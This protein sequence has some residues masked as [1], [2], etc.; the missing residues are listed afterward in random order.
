M[1]LFDIFAHLFL[2][3]CLFIEARVYHD[4]FTGGHDSLNGKMLRDSGYSNYQ[5]NIGEWNTDWARLSGRAH[6]QDC[7][8][9]PRNMTLC[10]D[11]G[12]NR[13]RLPNL[14]DHDTV[15][16]ATQQASSWNNL[17]KIK[18]HADA[19]LFLCSLFSP[20]CLDYIIRPCKSLCLAVKNGCESYLLKYGY[21]WPDMLNCDQ[22]PGDNNLCIDER[23]GTSAETDDKDV[24]DVISSDIC[25]VCN[26][27]V[28]EK[29]MQKSFCSSDVVVKVKIQN[30]IVSGNLMRVIPRK[31]KKF[32]KLEGLDASIKG[33]IEFFIED[34]MHCECPQVEKKSDDY[35]II[36]ASIKP[37][38]T[39]TLLIKS[40]MQYD[41]KS[42]AQKKAM[43]FL[44][45]KSEC[46]DQTET[47]SSVIPTTTVVTATTP[48]IEMPIFIDVDEIKKDV[49][50]DK[51]NKKER[52]RNKKGSKKNKKN[53]K[54]RKEPRDERG[55]KKR[56]RKNKKRDSE[57]KSRNRKD[58]K[59]SAESNGLTSL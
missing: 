22:F 26:A 51:S 29:A 57:R 56:G 37:G 44:R 47:L 1:H 59:S 27:L 49:D 40:V 11:I 7:I 45:K 2:S 28:D 25:P 5:D 31:K 16:E 19:Q 24:V 21:S 38:M 13:M 58:R 4:E 30:S 9:I 50:G 14:L 32:Y 3:S 34:G 10:H 54:E 52:K 41:K 46:P 55:K 42:S 8:E 18:C 39:D 35:V 33:K 20:I 15:L 48:S 12:Y 23:S 53:K 17:L 36:A 43:R 6:S